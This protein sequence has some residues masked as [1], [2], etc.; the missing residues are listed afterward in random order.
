MRTPLMPCAC[1]KPSNLRYIKVRPC[2]KRC[3]P[4]YWHKHLRESGMKQSRRLSPPFSSRPHGK[5]ST[6][7]LPVGAGG[8]CLTSLETH[9][10]GAYPGAFY[11]I[12]GP[13]QQR[14]TTM[15]GCT[16]RD[17]A[18]NLQDPAG[19]RNTQQWAHIVWEAREARKN[20]LQSFTPAER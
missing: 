17:V 5:G 19:C 3:P 20:L 16:N 8:A 12:A 15:G 6:H 11:K 1:Y 9:A 14:L 7:T 2:F 13:L 4:Y 18:A 10:W